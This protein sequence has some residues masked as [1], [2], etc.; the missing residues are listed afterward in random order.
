MSTSNTSIFGLR[1]NFQVEALQV[2]QILLWTFNLSKKSMHWQMP[3]TGLEGAELL[4]FLRVAEPEPVVDIGDGKGAV[5]IAGALSSALAPKQFSGKIVRWSGQRLLEGA[6]IVGCLNGG[7]ASGAVHY[8]APAGAGLIRPI[9]FDPS[10]SGD[11]SNATAGADDVATLEKAQQADPNFTRVLIEAIEALPEAFV[12][13]GPDDRM[14]VCNEQYRKLYPTVADMMAP[15]LSF[16]DV[17]SES[18]RRGVFQ[19]SE[20]AKQWSRKRLSFHHA[21][22]GFFEQHLSD[23]RWIQVSERKTPSGATSSIRADIT[24]LKEREADLR[25]ALD[26]ANNELAARNRFVAKVGHELRNPL[27]VVYNLAQ[28]LK[29]ERNSPSQQRT[30]DTLFGAASAM[31]D[32]LGDFLDVTSLRSGQ[33]TVDP[34][35]TDT[36]ELLREII[37]FSRL[38]GR[39]SAVS[40]RSRTARNIPRQI[41]T[42]RHRIRQIMFNLLG[43][44]FKYARG[45]SVVLSASMAENEDG[46]SVLRIAVT[47]TGKGIGGTLGGQIFTP[48]TR[49]REHRLEGIEG[50]GLGLAI[51]EELAAALGITLGIA[52]VVEGGTRAW[53]DIPIVSHDRLVN[54]APRSSAPTIPIGAGPAMDV[55]VIDDEPANLIVAESV[56]RRLGHRVTTAQSGQQALFLLQGRSFDAA[57]LDISM[58]EM[59]GVELAHAI[60]A[61]GLSANGMG[62]IAMTGNVMPDDIRYYFD[63]GITGFVEKPVDIQSLA[64]ALSALRKGPSGKFSLD[65][66][67]RVRFSLREKAGTFDRD[68]LNRMLEDIGHENVMAIVSSSIVTMQA[69]LALVKRGGDDREDLFRALHK[70][71]SVAGLLG[72]EPLARMAQSKPSTPSHGD[73]QLDELREELASAIVQL[74]GYAEELGSR[75]MSP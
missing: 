53:I 57:L 46:V 13:Y 33:F 5:K 38:L 22:I 63:A 71:Q 50:L 41:L 1:R 10:N 56:L 23:G 39:Q 12:L 36:R 27:N 24:I 3:A 14:V 4:N 74:Q 35:P 55:L 7:M 40:F 64:E 67:E 42:D 48:Y 6:T 11:P 29:A 47:D 30:L 43:N 59:S 8:Q 2:D 19:L 66:Q 58:P 32:V 73:L 34:K 21:N 61:G 31:R 18:V 62:L 49:N 60:V 37:D 54:L 44:A 25:A 16:H 20:D 28:L 17:M 68:R 45:G 65:P 51:S 52:P 75:S 70:V 9:P 26:Q 15:G 69:A 72:F